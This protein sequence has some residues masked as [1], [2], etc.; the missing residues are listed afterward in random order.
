[1]QADIAYLHQTVFK[2]VHSMKLIVKKSV[3][4]LLQIPLVLFIYQSNNYADS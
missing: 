3:V 2:S 1:M 4:C